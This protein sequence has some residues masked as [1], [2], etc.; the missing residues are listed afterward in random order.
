VRAGD[1]DRERTIATLRDATLA[2]RLTLEEFAGRVERNA[3]RPRIRTSGPFGTLR[4][5][6]SS[7]SPDGL[8][9]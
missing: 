3:P 1:A 5:A 4:V 9:E 7:R 8:T 2:G 6:T